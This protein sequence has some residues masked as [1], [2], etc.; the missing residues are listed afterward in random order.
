[1]T[2]EPEEP[3]SRGLTVVCTPQDIQDLEAGR[4]MRRVC[5]AAPAGAAHYGCLLIIQQALR[6]N[7]RAS[8]YVEKCVMINGQPAG[9][10]KITA[11]KI[12]EDVTGKDGH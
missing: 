9:S 7:A 8:E 2:N 1:M 4:L 5:Q 3:V 11:E 6:L 12:S 10:W